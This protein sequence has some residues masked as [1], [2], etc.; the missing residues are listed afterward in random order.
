MDRDRLVIA[1]NPA[2]L[3]VQM[4]PAISKFGQ[5]VEVLD[6]HARAGTTDIRPNPYAFADP[7]PATS[8]LAKASGSSTVSNPSKRAAK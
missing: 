5:E 4:A 8:F 3:D 2:V 7:N 1:V 6:P